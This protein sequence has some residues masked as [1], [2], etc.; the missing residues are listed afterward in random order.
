[1]AERAQ[2]S[3]VE[4]LEFFRSN[5]VLY[6]NQART[7]LEDVGGDVLRTRLWLQ[8]DQ[9][10]YWES[11][12]R[13]RQKELEQARQALSIA[14]LSHLG[15]AGGEEVMVVQRAKRALE[16]AEAKLKRLKQWNREF[17]NRVAPLVKQVEQLQTVLA[18]D[19]HQALAYLAQAVQTL[20]DYAESTPPAAA[21]AS[22][23]PNSENAAGPGGV[24][25]PDL[26]IGSAG[27]KQ[28]PISGGGSA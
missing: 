12:V 1:M 13:R 9:R 3:S 18:V 5:L 21:P 2:V 25:G 26:E 10:I 17:D 16:E 6:L 7:T 20:S 19:L 4:A 23:P 24:S 8:D 27:T 11:Q 14:R 15:E 22:A 28:D